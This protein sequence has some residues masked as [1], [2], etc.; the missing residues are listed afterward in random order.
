MQ[1]F[2]VPPGVYTILVDAYGASGWGSS[3]GGRVQSY[4]SVKPSEILQIDLGGA[5]D[6]PAY[7]TVFYP[8]GWVDC[9]W[10]YNGGMREIF[11]GIC[12]YFSATRISDF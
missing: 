6:P 9:P 11:H 10:S 3:N 1:N 5:G 4:L 7:S 2:T 12:I 8:N